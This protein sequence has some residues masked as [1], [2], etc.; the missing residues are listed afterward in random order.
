METDGSNS[1]QNS[2]Y[3]VK[4]LHLHN[5]LESKSGLLFFIDTIPRLNLYSSGLGGKR[6][7]G[8]WEVL[9]L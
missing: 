3:I 9:Y 1:Y 2:N 7:Y 4:D 6:E 8:D 5:V